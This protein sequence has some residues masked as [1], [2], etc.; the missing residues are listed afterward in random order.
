ICPEAEVKLFVTA[1]PE[2]RARRRWQETGE[3]SYQ[4]VLAQVRA[5]V[6]NRLGR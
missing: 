2:T 3:G 1:S 6:R 4:N 5:I